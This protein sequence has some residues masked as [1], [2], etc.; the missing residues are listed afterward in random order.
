M[1]RKHYTLLA[2]GLILGIASGWLLFGRDAAQNTNS[3]ATMPMAHDQASSGQ[4]SHP[5]IEVDATKPVPSVSI[6]SSPDSKD[7]YNL[8]FVTQNFT[9]TPENISKSPEANTGHMHL[10]VNGTKVSR[11]YGSW[12]HLSKNAL[13]DGENKIEVTLNANDHSDWL[14]NGQHLAAQITLTK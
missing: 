10:Y 8:H 12:Y 5:E 9:L 11:L 14:H 7:G 6:E 1:T 3:M 4:Q 13:K 2:I